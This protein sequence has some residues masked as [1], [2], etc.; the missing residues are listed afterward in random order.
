MSEWI[1]TTEYL[2]ENETP[3]LIVINGAIR[4]GELR[5]EHPG[6]E[7]TYKSFQYWDDPE[8]DGQIWDWVDVTHWMPLPELP[9][10]V[11]IEEE[12]L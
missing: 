2:P 5:W 9:I 7:D 3:V 4:I 8:D 12:I 1:E 6:F 11:E 10:T